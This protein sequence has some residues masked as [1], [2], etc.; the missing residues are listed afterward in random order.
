MQ[1]PR[2]KLVELSDV[3][4]ARYGGKALGLAKLAAAGFPVPAAFVI[5]NAD[6]G[7][8]PVDL[9]AR[10]A[11]MAASAG[12]VAVRSSAS[13]E[14]GLESSFAGQYETVLDVNGYEELLAAIRHCAAGA[15][16]ERAAAYRPG[17]GMTGPM[18][19]V[20]Q[21]MV[22]ARAAGV[23]F[24]AD[25]ASGRRD[26]C[27]VDAVPGPGE[28]LV[29][30]SA[31]SDHYEVDRA[32][33]IM[34][35]Q[36]ASSP[37]LT[38]DEVMAVVAG[39]RAAE[40]RWEM[41]LDLE[42]A[43]DRTGEIRWLQARPITTLPGDLNEMDSTVAGE[44]HVY[45][46]CNI[47]EM[48]PG[49]F[50]P[51]T[52]SV[53][54]RAI[55]YA[56]QLVQ[57]AG[58]FQKSY[59]EDRWLQLGY[60]SGHLFLN[61]TEGTALS[62][63]ILGNSLE[64]YSL[65]IAGRVVDELVPKPPKPFARRLVNTVRLTAF[66]LSAGHA[67][68]RL[69]RELARFE[70]PSAAEP[71]ALLA[72]LDA[73]IEL[74][75]EATLTHVRSSSRSAVAANVLEQTVL[76]EA[77]RAGRSEDEGRSQAAAMMAGAADV[78]SAVML[79]QLDDVVGR[80]AGDPAAA[81][82]FLERDAAEA[83]TGLT[84]G[85][86]PISRTFNEFLR[87]HGHRGYR[88]LCMRDRSWRDDPDGLGTIMQA[89]L[90]ARLN[91]GDAV[92]PTPA[93]PQQGV[94]R[95]VR[96]M[97]RLAQAGARGR[98][99]TKSRMVMVAYLLSRGYRLLGERLAAAGRLPDADLVFFFDRS[100]LP[101]LVGTGD[102]RDLID[103]AAARRSALPFQARLEFPDVSVGK[104]V[105]TRPKPPEGIE[106]GVIVGRPACGGVVEGTVRVATT[107]A[108][109]RELHPGEI[110]V[111]PVTDVG[112]TPYFT[113]IAALVTD[114]GSSVSHGAVVARE[115]GLPC[116]VNTQGATRVLR[117]GDRVRVDGDRGTVTLLNRTLVPSSSAT[118]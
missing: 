15:S 28:S 111:A 11:R 21:E 76:R 9:E 4:D 79:E 98:E 10:Y 56:M 49:A 72:E 45:T 109:A 74:Y 57:V 35:R 32:G 16:T 40:A 22:D 106:D 116:V 50:C 112:W 3:I 19:L 33:K 97:A 58:G 38:D 89:M 12:A 14:D 29:D 105:P 95:T 36:I 68:R 48:M 61:M 53:S 104:P 51:L 88:E 44:D 63:G 93:P 24:T 86:G 77:T 73:G 54:G 37:A 99:A 43:I 103:R 66:A 75:N 13:G 6:A 7:D 20:V 117:T 27:V 83:V 90:R 70:A 114:I 47:G 110:L 81:E 31:S 102:V 46:R 91:A 85:T 18:H 42:W 60:F 69:D 101:A 25:P 94:S 87:R 26:I 71:A 62:S 65:S 82:A 2:S 100:E 55:E 96:A 78:E 1:Q 8:L 30:G 34:D 107:V 118:A 17:A 59:R 113:L 39:A 5:A 115:Y 64:Q 23:V 41:P 52:A 80:L 92:R 108:Q 84:G 67:I